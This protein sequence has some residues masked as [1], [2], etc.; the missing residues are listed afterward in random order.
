[1]YSNAG[2]IS[3]GFRGLKSQ[4]LAPI[5][6]SRRFSKNTNGLQLSRVLSSSPPWGHSTEK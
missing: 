6:E 1:M 4:R 5:F 3:T 2:T